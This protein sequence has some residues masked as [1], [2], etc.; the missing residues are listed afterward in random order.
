MS[1]VYVKLKKLSVIA[2]S[3]PMQSMI[4]QSGTC[5]F[6]SWSQK[7]TPRVSRTEERQF[8]RTVVGTNFKFN[9]CWGG[10]GGGAS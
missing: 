8:P 4:R 3:M 7:S 10:G 2:H 6:V 5:V 9:A 1:Y